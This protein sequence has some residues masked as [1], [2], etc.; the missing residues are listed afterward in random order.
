MRNSFLS[1]NFEVLLKV[2][3]NELLEVQMINLSTGMRVTDMIILLKYLSFTAILALK[4]F[5]RY[6]PKDAMT[7]TFSVT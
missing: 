6:S 4:E 7:V 2:T 5:Q 3:N 1:E